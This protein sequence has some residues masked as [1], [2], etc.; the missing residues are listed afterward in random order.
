[1][2]TGETSMVAERLKR[3]L[4]RAAISFVLG[5]AGT[6]IGVVAGL[7][8]HVAASGGVDHISS[9]AAGIAFMLGPLAGAAGG[10]I[11]AVAVPIWLAR[12]DSAPRPPKP[13]RRKR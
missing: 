2:L 8:A 10:L 1:M 6:Y 7:F 13:S 11:C 12:Q 5:F 9:V 3:A 4:R